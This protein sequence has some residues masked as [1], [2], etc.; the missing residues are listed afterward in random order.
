MNQDRV[1]AIARDIRSYYIERKNSLYQG[2]FKMPPQYAD[3]IHWQ[4]AAEVCIELG[5][6]PEV[7]VDA[8]FS[9]CNLNLGPYPNTMYG[10]AIRRWYNSYMVG[11]EDIINSRKKSIENGKDPMF[12]SSNDLSVINLRSEIDFVER[13]L[14]RLTGTSAI[15]SETINYVAGLS[16]NY[17]AHVR[18]LLGAKNEKVKKFFGAD[19]LNYFNRNA[20]AYRAA[21][22]LGYPIREILLWLSAPSN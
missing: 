8:A 16:V 20:G 10:N 18:A 21:E 9:H 19:A 5:A 7:Y 2:R 4:K 14:L 1:N 6:T 17:P 11:R 22:T 3:F 15:N 12:D 13:S